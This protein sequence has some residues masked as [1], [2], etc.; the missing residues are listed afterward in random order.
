VDVKNT[1][2]HHS[3]SVSSVSR[4]FSHLEM[5]ICKL[6][7]KQMQRKVD[8]REGLVKA[9]LKAASDYGKM[10]GPT[11]L[12]FGIGTCLNPYWKLNLFRECDLDASGETEY[13]K[14][15]KKEFIAYYDLYYA[16]I[17]NQAPDI[18]IPRSGQNS[19]SKHL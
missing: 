9:K 17:N 13:E 6:E 16:L 4:Y 3:S 14:S 1:W 7:Q 10:E 2:R 8:I 15:Y 18:S 12:L 11:G 5:Q 19:R